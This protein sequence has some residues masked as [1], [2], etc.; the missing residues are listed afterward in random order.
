MPWLRGSKSG[1][2]SLGGEQ[3]NRGGDTCQC[4]ERS[5]QATALIA[6]TSLACGPSPPAYSR[7]I[8]GSTG[9]GC[10]TAQQRL[11]PSSLSHERGGEDVR[12]QGGGRSCTSQADDLW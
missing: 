6:T 3:G 11:R 2:R 10:T 8:E 9:G 1:E 7:S 4:R 12:E 5:H